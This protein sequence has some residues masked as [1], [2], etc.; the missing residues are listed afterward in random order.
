MSG[1]PGD[2]VEVAGPD[3]TLLRGSKP[4]DFTID[5]RSLEKIINALN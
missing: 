1:C 4:V 3:L 5:P 2:V